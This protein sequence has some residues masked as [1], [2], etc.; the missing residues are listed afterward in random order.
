MGE[1]YAVEKPPR[2]GRLGTAEGRIGPRRGL[3]GA[4]AS[5]RPE[6]VV[7]HSRL[8]LSAAVL[9]ST[10]AAGG[11]VAGAATTTTLHATLSGKNELNGAG[12]AKGK[13]TFQAT[14]KS[15]KLCYTL[16]FS[17]IS[18]PVAS[19]IHKGTSK[20]N[21]PIALDLKPKFTKNG[22]AGCVTVKSTLA[23]AIKK[24]PQG[25]YVNVHTQKYSGGAIR[26]Q[27]AVG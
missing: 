24:N 18:Q 2:G 7:F 12:A 5:N 6:A 27:L 14:I 8:A 15:G 1:R 10:L 3:S 26:G 20:D 13:G 17:G 9:T 21:G 19:H 25:Y 16:K 23:S 4:E 22:A 11:A